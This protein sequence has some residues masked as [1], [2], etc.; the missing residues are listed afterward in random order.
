MSSLEEDREL[1]SL[2]MPELIERISRL[3]AD[4]SEAVEHITCEILIRTM[5]KAE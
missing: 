3:T 1:A 4:Y 5:Q 2:T